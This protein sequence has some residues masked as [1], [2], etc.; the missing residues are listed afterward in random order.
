MWRTV[1][2]KASAAVSVCRLK[3]V[4]ITKISL[5]G[6]Q[7][8]AEQLIS[9]T[10]KAQK[11]C[12]CIIMPQGNFMF[13]WNLLIIVL[14]AYSCVY[15]PVEVAFLEFSANKVDKALGLLVDFLFACDI[16]VNF[17]S[18]HEVPGTNAYEVRLSVLAREY[19]TGWFFID[20]IACL[21]VD[22]FEFIIF[23]FTDETDTSSARYAKLARIPRVYRIVRIVRIFKILKIFKY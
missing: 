10:V 13:I 9:R 21:P 3:E 18:A 23:F 7:L 5:F 15:V 12:A 6:R 11:V 1:W 22:V 16:V 2:N 8:L 4:V 14:L 19:L 20:F 17:L